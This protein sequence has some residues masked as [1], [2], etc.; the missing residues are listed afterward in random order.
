LTLAEFA[1]VTQKG[2]TLPE[3]R[4]GNHAVMELLA[5]LIELAKEGGLAKTSW[6]PL[7]ASRILRSTNAKWTARMSMAKCMLPP[8]KLDSW[9]PAPDFPLSKTLRLLA[10]SNMEN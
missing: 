4:D 3:D 6:N 9:F 1:P 10:S 7:H 2:R 8:H 5:Q